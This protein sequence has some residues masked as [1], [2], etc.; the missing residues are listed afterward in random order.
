MNCDCV[1][2]PRECPLH[3]ESDVVAAHPQYVAMGQ[4]R[5]HA[6]QQTQSWFITSV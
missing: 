2:S 1:V 4:L 3:P 6:A 5:T